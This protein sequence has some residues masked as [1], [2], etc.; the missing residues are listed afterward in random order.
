[1]VATGIMDERRRHL[2]RTAAAA[3]AAILSFGVRAVEPE[4]AAEPAPSLDPAAAVFLGGRTPTRPE[5]A[6]VLSGG[7]ARGAAH[8][9]V[10]KVLEELHVVP[11]LIVGTSMGSIVGGL[12]AAGYSPEEIEE[13]LADTDWGA[14]FVDRAPR[15]DDSF[16]RKKDDEPILIP[17]KLRFKGIR[18]Y[19]PSGILGGNSVEQL[20]RS[21]TLRATDATD[22]DDLPIP[23][24]AVAADIETGQAV[25]LGE[26]RLSDAMRASMSI[27]GT[28]AP[29]VIDGRRLVDGGAVA[30][31]P[32]GIAQELGARRV[33]VVDISSPLEHD[34]EQRS[35]MGILGQLSGLLTVGNRAVDIARMRDGDV[36]LRPDL[37]DVS[38]SAFKRAREAVGY[39]E[40]AARAKIAAL[41]AFSASDARWAEF[42][43]SHRKRDL[44][45][46]PVEA[47][48]IEN[49]SWVDDG[50]VAALVDVPTGAPLDDAK[51]RSDLR[52]LYAL[53]YFGVLRDDFDVRDGRGTLTL[54]TPAKPYGRGSLQFGLSLESDLQGAASYAF[55]VRH[56]VLAV[57]RRAGEWVN[58]GQ[59]G[60]DIVFRS[61]FYQPFDPGLR[62]FVAPSVEYERRTQ[63]IWVDGNPVADYTLEGRTARLDAGR[64]FGRWGDLRLGLFRGSYSAFPRIGLSIFPS[65]DEE[66]GGVRLSFRAD[67]ED[68]VAFPTRGTRAE[69]DLVRSD[70]ALGANLEGT[71]L[72]ADLEKAISAGQGTVVL[73]AEG[74]LNVHGDTAERSTVLLGGF[75][76]LS[77]LG[78]NE[79]IGKKGGIVRAVFYYDLVRL[80]L[81]ALSN[82]VF[83]GASLEAGN[84]Y[85]ADD[86][87]TWK[88]LRSGG[89]LFVGAETVA[90]PV[91]LGWGQTED[92]DHWYFVFGQRF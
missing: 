80:E 72:M 52:T 46:V 83:I 63:N 88:S 48:K 76:R 69:I 74:G 26:G 67:T 18:P 32:V 57:N 47:V 40:E 24:R 89:A 42:V 5:L 44:A 28:F 68:T 2:A 92:R 10:L 31:V 90:G 1:M 86:P 64:V 23:Y 70:E 11:D 84:A 66:G 41:R 82:R 20:L 21:L 45:A 71:Y 12:Y 55:T 73:G 85:A 13:I 17:L 4:P 35:F 6:L 87:V 9:G 56:M 43:A 65:F 77:G 39:G 29:A 8:I 78:K 15:E 91:Y 49:S 14:V 50:V 79:L 16:R 27:A 38:F 62:W 59:F 19:M 3:A 61:E 53:D 51:L 36:L 37:R 75:L 25:V 22:F 33:I 30:N 7:G 81:G 34:L 54:R 60:N 58:I